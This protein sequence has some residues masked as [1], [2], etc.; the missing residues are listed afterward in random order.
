MIKQIEVKCP[1]KA[2]H[3][4]ERELCSNDAFCCSIDSSSQPGL[5][6]KHK[7][8]YQI[9]GQMAITKLHTCNFIVWTPNEFT[10]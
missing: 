9:Q 6:D 4:T 1:Y 7:Y 5:K 10:V 3:S 8:Y 2:C